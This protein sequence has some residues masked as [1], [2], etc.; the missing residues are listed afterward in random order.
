MCLLISYVK[1]PSSYDLQSNADNEKKKNGW[2]LTFN[3]CA[4]TSDSR[5]RLSH[6]VYFYFPVSSQV[7]FSLSF[8]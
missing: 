3:K 1:T 2:R 7:S 8:V 5:G 4:G 6:C